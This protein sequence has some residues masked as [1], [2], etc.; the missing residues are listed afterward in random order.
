M[1]AIMCLMCGLTSL[2]KQNKRK[3]CKNQ[4]QETTCFIAPNIVNI[5]ACSRYVSLLKPFD[6]LQRIPIYYIYGYFSIIN[7][8]SNQDHVLYLNCEL[9]SNIFRSTYM[10]MCGIQ[11]FDV[12][13][14]KYLNC[15]CFEILKPF[16]LFPKEK[17]ICFF[18]VFLQHILNCV[19][20]M[21]LKCIKVC[22]CVSLY[23]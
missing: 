9:Y 8:F 6:Q 12:Q 10:T 17:Q 22:V 23:I 2:C 11:V 4:A 15:G 7:I 20:V 1:G 16:F 5:P 13:M 18:L 21:A 3:Q 14:H 19:R